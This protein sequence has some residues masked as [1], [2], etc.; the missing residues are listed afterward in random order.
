MD[1]GEDKNILVFP[2]SEPGTF[3]AYPVMLS[4]VD[5]K[6]DVRLLDEEPEYP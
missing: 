1:F 2:G 6:N 5:Q 4:R 3:G